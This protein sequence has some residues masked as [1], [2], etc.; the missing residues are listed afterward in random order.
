MKWSVRFLKNHKE[1]Q[2]FDAIWKALRPYP[3]FKVAKQAYREV[4]QW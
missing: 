1:R 4:T 2:V 3:G